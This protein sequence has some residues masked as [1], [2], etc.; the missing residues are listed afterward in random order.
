VSIG[1][2]VALR[3]A[4]ARDTADETHGADY[5]ELVETARPAPVAGAPTR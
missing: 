3:V 4:G 1:L 5:D 2:T